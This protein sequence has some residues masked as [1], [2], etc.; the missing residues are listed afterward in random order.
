MEVARESINK[1][2]TDGEYVQKMG[3]I[4]CIARSVIIMIAISLYRTSPSCCLLG[5]SSI[6][7]FKEGPRCIAASS[8]HFAPDHCT[9]PIVWS[10]SNAKYGHKCS[11]RWG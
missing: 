6:G 10:F 9:Y 3:C 4:T 7:V 2:V 8:Q 1:N 11:K 5:R